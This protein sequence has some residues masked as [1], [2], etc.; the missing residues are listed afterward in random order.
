MHWSDITPFAQGYVEAL[1]ESLSPAFRSGPK[2]SQFG[3]SDLSPEALGMILK[4]CE[5][6]EKA[7]P[8]QAHDPRR[9]NRGLNFWRNRQAGMWTNSGFP[10]LTSY[11]GATGPDYRRVPGAP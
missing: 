9:H 11:L 10:P 4:D 1:F 5:A 3:F 2:S 7:Y 8:L 6:H